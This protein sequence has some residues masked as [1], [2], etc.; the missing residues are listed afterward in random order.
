MFSLSVF[1]C[2]CLASLHQ[3]WG[4]SVNALVSAFRYALGTSRLFFIQW[5]S[6]NDAQMWKVGL[7]APGFAWDLLDAIATH[8]GCQIDIGQLNAATPPAAAVAAAGGAA[9]RKGNGV[10][11]G[12]ALPRLLKIAGSIVSS[13][14]LA[15]SLDRFYSERLGASSRGG[16]PVIYLLSDGVLQNFL[17]RPNAR[18]RDDWI[19]PV[20]ARLTA[21]AAA[22]GSEDAGAVTVVGMQIRSGYADAPEVAARPS[23]ANFLAPGDEK[24]F[25]AKLVEILGG[26]QPALGDNPKPSQRRVKVFLMTDHPDIRASVERQ[27]VE[28]YGPSLEVVSVSG[29][30]VAHCGPG[31]VVSQAALLRM[32]AEWFV[33]GRHTQ[34][35]LV[36]AWSLFGAS[37]AALA[38]QGIGHTTHNVWTIDASNCG[39]PGAKPC[40]MR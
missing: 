9:T 2:V 37:A 38:V 18:L 16:M 25:V 23:N 29:G 6:R 27:L 12:A 24:L 10:A 7:E 3:G 36:T 33:F 19:A 34:H 40:Q 1:L 30:S 39:Q 20:V 21:V 22:E 11:D 5:A 35:R 28:L 31:R 8:P 32:L 15:G 13:H 17:L 4:D 26:P 14:P